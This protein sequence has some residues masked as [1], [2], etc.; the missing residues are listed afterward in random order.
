MRIRRIHLENHRRHRNVELELPD[1]VLAIVG[2]NGSGKSS[3]LE[4]IG[5]ALFGAQATRTPK[6]LLRHTEAAPSDPVR[7]T[8]EMELAGQALEVVRE[9]R[10][11]N[12]T[13]HARLS[14]D[15]KP[16]VAGGA[17]SHASVTQEIERLL[18]MDR[19]AFFTSI[20]AQQKELSRLA[21]LKPAER[22]ALILR[23][24]GIDAVDRAIDEGRAR[25]RQQRTPGHVHPP[26]VLHRGRRRAQH[27][28]PLVDAEQRGRVGGGKHREQCGHQNEATAAHDRIHEAGKQRGQRDKQQF[29]AGDCHREPVAPW[30]RRD[31][32]HG[33]GEKKPTLSGRFE[34]SGISGGR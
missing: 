14:M 33:T 13:A 18:G 12:L 22:K 7:V 17:S 8:L 29:H 10:G 3:I 4:A 23:L 15:G 19:N 16:L 20:V 32:A 24:L 31:A 11:L 21:D 25:R 26:R 30:R 2:P 1:G 9:F 34:Q 28:R 6:A 5:F 27:G